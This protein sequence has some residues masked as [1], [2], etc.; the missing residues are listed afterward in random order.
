MVF[1]GIGKLFFKLKNG[2]SLRHW[3]I[4]IVMA[5]CF[6]SVV[7]TFF[8][9]IK[10]GYTVDNL[11]F[12]GQVNYLFDI[13]CIIGLAVILYAVYMK[14]KKPMLEKVMLF[15]VTFFYS[16]II[17]AQYDNTF[18]CLLVA[19]LMVFSVAYC[20]EGVNTQLIKI[21]SV[22]YKLILA[23][24]FVTFVG[25]IGGSLVLKYL[26]YSSPN[27]DLGLFSQMFHY[28]SSDLSMKTTS[29]RDV[30]LSHF[31]VH[32]SPIFYCILPLYMLY[33]SAATL[34]FAQALV[35]GLA[36]FPLAGICRHLKLS[37]F[38]TAL[39]CIAY[40]LYPVVSGGCFYDIHENIFLPLCIFTLLYYC[41]KESWI[42]IIIS[43]VFLLGVKEDAAVYAVCIG[44]YTLF[45]KKMYKKS[46]FIIVISGLY[47]I[48]TTELLSKIGESVMSY[49]FDNMI[50]GG[51]G[52]MVGIIRTVITNPAYILTQI[53]Q[54]EKIEFIIQTLAP[55]C[56]MPLFSKKWYRFIF[57]IPYVLFNLMSDYQYFHSIYFQYVFGSGALLFYL[58]VR[59]VADIDIKLRSRIIPMV[60]VAS[61]L[62]F[63]TLVSGK[64]EKYYNYYS[65]KY[66]RSIYKVLDE[67]VSSVPENASV[68][69]TTFLCPALSNRD[70]LYELYYTDKESET[71][72]TVLDLRVATTEY[73]VNTYLD[74]ED[75]EVVY[76]VPFRVGVFKNKKY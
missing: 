2:F 17:T 41:E 72:Y 59:N 44:L 24:G 50:Y 60:T 66:E 67:A 35:I 30:L 68:T 38:E 15:V 10:Q 56:F 12:T 16:I 6:V 37:R 65:D 4:S 70:V 27:F 20:F 3:V 76:Y 63:I 8:I 45:Y 33:K 75:Y 36:V 29:E 49:R 13:I 53:M 22:T 40:L 54:Q 26:T 62:F 18:Y 42:G 74:S 11:N 47:F 71:E 19:G 7:Q 64:V 48:F 21:H 1:G 46:I 52:S 31:C 34:Q 14:L 39:F 43:T 58:S 32:I 9:N 69:A 55:L 57:F 25:V 73:N 23:I 51:G 5:W 28:M 61:S